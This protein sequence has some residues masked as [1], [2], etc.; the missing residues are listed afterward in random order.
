MDPNQMMGELVSLNSLQQ[1]M[2]IKQDLDNLTGATSGGGTASGGG[3][4]PTGSS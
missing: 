3:T 2:G 4:T 1:L